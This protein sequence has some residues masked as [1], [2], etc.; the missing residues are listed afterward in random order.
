MSAASPADLPTVRQGL[1]SS[2]QIEAAWL[3][4]AHPPYSSPSPHTS[5]AAGSDGRAGATVRRVRGCGAGGGAGAGRI[6]LWWCSVRGAC[7]GEAAG[8]VVASTRRAGGG[9]TAASS[10]RSGA[11]GDGPEGRGGGAETVVQP[12]S[13]H[14]AQ[15][16]NT[17]ATNRGMP[18]TPA[19]VPYPASCGYSPHE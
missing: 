4:G 18:R 13:A 14:T 15:I 3:P 12:A 16:A 8:W 6:G 7:G 19:T 11:V 10:G 5:G 17:G 1:Y 2:R 9:G